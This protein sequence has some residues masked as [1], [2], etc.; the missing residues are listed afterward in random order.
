[1][2]ADN[3]TA[4][5]HCLKIKLPRG[6][7]ADCRYQPKAEATAVAALKNDLTCRSAGWFLP[8]VMQH[9]QKQPTVWNDRRRG[10]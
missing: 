5:F 7:C 9:Y 1:M 2:A 6:Q 10:I 4:S 3:K 8:A